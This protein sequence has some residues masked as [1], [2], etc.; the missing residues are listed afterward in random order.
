MRLKY[1]DGAKGFCIALVVLGHICRKNWLGTIPV[2]LIYTVNVQ[3]FFIISGVFLE[4]NKEYQRNIK[5]IITSNVIRLLVPYYCFETIYNLAYAVI[6]GFV[7]FRWQEIDTFIF[8]GRGI[9]TWFLSALLIAKIVLIL[10]Y[11]TRMNRKLV[12][13]IAFVLF[14]IGLFHEVYYPGELHW[15]LQ[16]FFR[17]LIGIGFLTIGAILYNNIEYIVSFRNTV[18]IYALFVAFLMAALFNGQVSTYKLE[19]NNPFLYVFTS[20]AGTLIVLRVFRRFTT[21][22]FEYWGR[23]SIIILGTHQAILCFFNAWIGKEYSICAA[24]FQWVII[25]L[26]E[27]PIIMIINRWVPFLVGKKKHLNK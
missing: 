19:F 3:A 11:K 7:T 9:A 1:I 4:K 5:D 21:R 24:V 12:Y 20:V 15:I 26:M 17:G 23:N 25:M 10:L 16:F 18:I 8:Y 27:F 13:L 2:I 22:I 14:G 6:N